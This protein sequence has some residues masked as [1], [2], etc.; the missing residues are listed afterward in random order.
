MAAWSDV[1]M[2]IDSKRLSKSIHTVT[3][4]LITFNHTVIH[5]YEIHERIE[6]INR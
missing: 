3:A 4:G 6:I 1:C 2:K 5:S